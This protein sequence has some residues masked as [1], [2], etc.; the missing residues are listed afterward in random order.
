MDDEAQQSFTKG[1][2][3]L[4]IVICVCVWAFHAI[5]VAHVWFPVSLV[6]IRVREARS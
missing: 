3:L 4:I 5:G 1:N 6:I 2:Q